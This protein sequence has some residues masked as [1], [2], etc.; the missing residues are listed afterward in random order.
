MDYCRNIFGR[1]GGIPGGRLRRAVFETS[2]AGRRGELMRQPIFAVGRLL[3]RTCAPSFTRL[4]FPGALLILALAGAAASAAVNTIGDVTPADNP[5]TPALNEGLPIDGNS[6]SFLEPPNEQTFFEGMHDS[7]PDM[8]DFTGDEQN[9]NA[10]VFV[11]TSSFGTLLISGGSQLRYMNLVIGDTGE[12]GDNLT[13]FGTGIVRI[14]GF[15]S[16]YNNDYNIIPPGLPTNFSSVNPR[17]DEGPM[18]GLD[19]AE[20]GFDLYV[21]RAGVGTLEITAGARA[22]IQ[23]A[24]I[25]GDMPGSQGNLV[26]DGIDSFL[27]SGGLEGRALGEIHQMIVGH[28]GGGTMTISNGATVLSESTQSGGSQFD[29]IGAVIGSDPAQTRTRRP[30]PGGR[31]TVNVIGPSSKWIIGGSVQIGGFMEGAPGAGDV[32][33]LDLQYNSE[34][35]RGTLS[36]QMGGLV[37]IRPAIDADTDNDDLRLLI[38]RFGRV[39]LAGGYIQMGY[40]GVTMD[41]VQLLNDGVIEGGGRIDTGVFRNRYLGEVRVGPGEALI[42]DSGS[43]FQ[44][45]STAEQP[46]AN[47]GVIEV[48]GT[49]DQPAEFEIE[50]AP[51]TD[52]DPVQ[53]FRNFRVPRPMAAPPTDFFGG[54]ISAQHSILRFRSALENQGMLA[55]TQGSNYIT[56]DV[57]NLGLPLPDPDQGIINVLG[58][59]TT[60]IFENDLINAGILNVQGGAV[61]EVLAR[62]SY[63]NTGDMIISLNPTSPTHFLIGGDAGISGE[64]TV[65]ISGF[66][67]GEL[68]IGDTFQIMTVAGDLGGVDQTDPL[69]PKPDLSLPPVFSEIEIV[70]SLTLFGLPPEAVMIPI[71]T[72]NSILLAIRSIAGIVGADFNGDRVVDLADL[73]ILQANIGITVGATPLQGD[74]DLDGDVDGHDFLLWQLQIG[75][76]P[77]SGFGSS[78]GL[79]NVPEP[80]G[81]VLFVSGLLAL[82]VARRRTR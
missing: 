56:G 80:A 32:E 50:R 30:D 44:S 72:E 55:F 42:I 43:E 5:F 53:P 17:A 39:A 1:A 28:L 60:A 67:P 82:A 41:N 7:G 48:L 10:N 26:V 61:V 14:T 21:G 3:L 34:T 64:L 2:F 11:G 33:G 68:E 40:P 78:A 20:D 77:A 73:A 74:A 46:L 12:I 18:D 69:R 25:V 36:V 9:T 47:W 59:G 6:I 4:S 29:T 57:F 19:G 63:V 13:R 45:G 31:G 65:N 8:I 16:L 66:S 54:L 52:M 79:A 81:T 38:G 22:E 58:E 76:V 62:H 15:G 35:G 71:F 24:V 27:G 75:P 51:N 49:E 23:D 70:P 37:Q